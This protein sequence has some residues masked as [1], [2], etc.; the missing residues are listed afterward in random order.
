MDEKRLVRMKYDRMFLGV[1]SGIAHYMN[2]DPVLVRLAFVLLFFL[3]A[4]GPV[5]LAYFVLAIVLP[6]EMDV[7]AKANVFDDEEI[8]IK[9]G[10]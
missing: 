10:S 3:T 4:G 5:L 2:L 8:V 1:A 7:A 9:D 6:E